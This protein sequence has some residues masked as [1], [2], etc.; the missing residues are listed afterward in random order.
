MTPRVL[1]STLGLFLLAHA[2]AATAQITSEGSIRGV[3]KDEQGAVLPG[4]TLTATTPQS[5]T[6]VTAVSDSQGFY[7]LMNLTPGTYDV[8]AALPGFSRFERKGLEVRAET[9]IQVDV[10]LKIGAIEETIQVTGDT[11][12]LEVQKTVQAIN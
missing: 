8:V 9:N 10:T 1:A 2:A 12:M 5:S 6:P 7:R 11:P 4:V 3:I